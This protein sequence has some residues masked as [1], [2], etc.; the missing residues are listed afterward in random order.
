[1]S[2][3]TAIQPKKAKDSNGHLPKAKKTGTSPRE[4]KPWPPNAFMKF[5]I[6]NQ[7]RLPLVF[8]SFL[9]LI[10]LAGFTVADKFFF[11][12]YFDAQT[13]LYSKGVDDAYFALFWVAAFTFLRAAVMRFVLDPLGRRMGINKARN[14]TRFAEQG[15]TFIY[16][17][18]FWSLGMYIMYHSPYWLDMRHF[19]IDYPHERFTPIFKSYY[20]VQ[21]AF[22]IQQICVLHMEKPRKDHNAMLMHHLVTCTLIIG[23]YIINFTRIG[24]AVL[25][26]MDFA[27]IL[28]PLAKILKYLKLQAICDFF[29]AMFVIAWVVTRHIFFPM[30]I[31][32]TA[33]DSVKYIEP[34]W[35]P[36][37]GRFFTQNTV[38][39]FL[40]LFA[41]LQLLLL[42]WFFL[43]CRVVYS[44]VRGNAAHDNR[45][46]SEGEEEEEAT[47]KST[48]KIGSNGLHAN[49]HANGKL[50]VNGTLTGNG[51]MNGNG[52]INGKT[53]RRI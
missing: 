8:T 31:Y 15:W 14:L 7:I 25:C 9:L 30:I 10:R 11:L 50:D 43:I 1:M 38:Y 52:K 3:S 53:K 20:L 45:S 4:G 42:F 28:L 37:E 49:G 12:S 39:F 5:I 6:E 18:S 2:R 46:D 47:S 51:R 26:V 34:L 27:D 32:N 21:L 41:I 23:S 44:V 24:N 16:Y 13:G 33:V 36:S 22:W 17:A 19:W 29:F 40:T 35:M 48:Q